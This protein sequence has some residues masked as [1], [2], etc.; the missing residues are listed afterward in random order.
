MYR[1][2]GLRLGG[3]VQ[4]C[5]LRMQKVRDPADGNSSIFADS[6]PDLAGHSVTSDK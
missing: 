4:R 5:R 1:Y 6:Q 3:I 2:G